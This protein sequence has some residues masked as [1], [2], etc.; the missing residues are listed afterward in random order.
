MAHLCLT[1]SNR[2]LTSKILIIFVGNRITAHTECIN[3][4]GNIVTI[5]LGYLVMDYNTIQS[6]KTKNT[7]DKLSYTVRSPF[8][9]IRGTGR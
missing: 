4:N 8:Q 3:N 7:V 2:F 6:Y 9:I 1:N 5:Y